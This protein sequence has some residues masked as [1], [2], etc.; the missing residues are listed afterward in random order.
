MPRNKSGKSGDAALGRSLMKKQRR[1]FDNV[2]TRHTT[3]IASENTAVSITENTSIDEF[4]TNA[5]AAQRSFEAVRGT[6]SIVTNDAEAEDRLSDVEE[7][8]DEEEDDGAEMCSVP[9]KSVW[10]RTQSAEEYQRQEQLDFLKWKRY[11][12][13]EEKKYKNL[14]PFE[15]NLEFWR[16][17]WR[18]IELSDVVVQVVDARDPLFY[19]CRDLDLYVKEVSEL[20]TNVVLMNKADFLTAE[21]RKAWTQYFADSDMKCLFF[22]AVDE[23]E[24]EESA[25][26]EAATFNNPRIL[27]PFEVLGTIEHLT[28]VT[29]LTVGFL[30]Y[31][32]VGKSS[33]INRFLT[34]K[35]LQVS[36][37]PGKTKH[38]QTHVL[39]GQLTLV[40]GPGLVIPNFSMTKADM[41]L[42]GILPIDNL[43]DFTPSVDLLL[44]KVPF[45]HI[46]A[47]YGIMRHLV[48]AA[49]KADRKS[50][51]MQMLSALALMRGFMK[52]G[53]VPDHF[54]A[55]KLVLKDYVQGKLRFCK[56]PPGVDQ[57]G[58]CEF[59]DAGPPLEDV[60]MSLEESFPELRMQSGVHVRGV[61]GAKAAGAGAKKNHG[62]K[63]KREKA[64]RLYNDPYS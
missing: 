19:Y 62:N 64:R 3:D 28:N 35:K 7:G 37:T 53:G 59:A 27:S 60:E 31:P 43:N 51:T 24:I 55:A 29:P 63:N 39:K 50:E 23:E 48:T 46:T 17:F 20:K 52:P 34:N 47:H 11:L 2:S 10:N 44:S 16:Q 40:D 54:K 58:F 45:S 42:A 38:Y 41:V 33:T 12:S 15:K 4:L 9:K 25:S 14:P 21:Q 5:E 57:E 61:K 1:R 22:S 26:D 56:A 30:G 36:A 6:A 49:R 8:D 32:N 18:I 13:K